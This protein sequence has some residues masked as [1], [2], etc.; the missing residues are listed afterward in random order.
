M[1]LNVKSPSEEIYRGMKGWYE[2]IS[3]ELELKNPYDPVKV[4]GANTQ[5]RYSFKRC[6]I[7]SVGY[8][9][10]AFVSEGILSKN[11]IVQNG[12]KK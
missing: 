3:N 2:D 9:E 5:A 4:I 1:G 12:F 10:D 8:G 11:S 6:L 7:E